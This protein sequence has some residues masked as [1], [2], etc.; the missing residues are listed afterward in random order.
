MMSSVP[1]R[2]YAK[3]ASKGK[4]SLDVYKLN[5]RK[6]D[7]VAYQSFV[8][9]GFYFGFRFWTNFVVV[10]RFSAIFGAGYSVASL[11]YCA[12]RPCTLESAKS[13]AGRYR[14]Q[15]GR[16]VRAPDLKAGGHGFKSRRSRVQVPL[17]PLSWS[18]FSVDPSSTPRSCL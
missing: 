13:L 6:W 12:G 7:Y 17:W 15:R 16:V 10:S 11:A 18:C 9:E 1:T 2:R 4:T 3:K 5:N 14:R 8:S